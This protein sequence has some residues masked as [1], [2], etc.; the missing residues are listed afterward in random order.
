METQPCWVGFR[1][2]PPLPP[3]RPSG[4]HRQAFFLVWL[5]E[6]S[7]AQKPQRDSFLRNVFCCAQGD[8]W[9]EGFFFHGSI[10]SKAQK[11]DVGSQ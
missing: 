6:H 5:L 9:L 10:E 11:Q 2:L 7:L 8:S 4:Q 1:L 3:S